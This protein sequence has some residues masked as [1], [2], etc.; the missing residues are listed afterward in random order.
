MRITHNNDDDDRTATKKWTAN[1]KWLCCNVW[2]PSAKLG[3]IHY[4]SKYYLNTHAVCVNA[5]KLVI[6]LALTTATTAPK[7][8]TGLQV[9]SLFQ[10]RFS[11]MVVNQ[12][13]RTTRKEMKSE[14]SWNSRQ[15]RLSQ[16][17]QFFLSFFCGRLKMWI[18]VRCA[19]EHS[20]LH[21]FKHTTYTYI[22]SAVSADAKTDF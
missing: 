1:T 17:N 10:F 8:K 16:E 19:Q 21:T 22:Q 14:K 3:I 4:N 11:H 7:M 18:C 20:L 6:M 2:R 9:C 15:T 5:Q 13:N 12:A